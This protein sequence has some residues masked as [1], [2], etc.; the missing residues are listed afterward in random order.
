M[1][2]EALV[3]LNLERSKSDA[4]V[5]F[6]KINPKECIILIHVDDMLITGKN[7]VLINKIVSD[8]ASK[9]KI[10]DLGDV[11]KFIGIENDHVNNVPYLS[12]RNYI[13]EILN[14]YNMSECNAVKT[15]MDANTKIVNLDYDQAVKE[16]S[17]V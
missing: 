9:F 1:V 16:K 7:K 15:P 11:K 4:C 5:Y 17:E 12:R 13:L 8:L 10:R 3:D 14:L 6:Y 2:H